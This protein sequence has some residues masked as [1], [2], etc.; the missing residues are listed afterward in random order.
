MLKSKCMSIL[1]NSIFEWGFC[2]LHLISVVVLD[3]IDLTCYLP[4]TKKEDSTSLCWSW[5]FIKH[6][7]CLLEGIYF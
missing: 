2:I 5:W 4:E 1:V 7:H 6:K 3:I